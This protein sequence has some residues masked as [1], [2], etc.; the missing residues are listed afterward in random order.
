MII[1]RSSLTA[2]TAGIGISLCNYAKSDFKF[3]F[4]NYIHANPQIIT[5]LMQLL[6]SFRAKNTLL[7][8]LDSLKAALLQVSCATSVLHLS[9]MIIRFLWLLPKGK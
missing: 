9:L 7:R 1:F 8:M 3:K 2:L 4:S 5:H 6:T